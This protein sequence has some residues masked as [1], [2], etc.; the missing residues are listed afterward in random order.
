MRH[1]FFCLAMLLPMQAAFAQDTSQTLSDR[2]QRD[3]QGVGVIAA[4]IENNTPVFTSLGVTQVGGQ[5]PVDA[6]T[7]FEIGSISK[8]FVNLLLAQMVLD[9]TMTLDDPLAQYL[10]EGTKLPAFDGQ[11]ITLRHLAT[12]RSGLPSVPPSLGTIDPLNP[13]E[14]F[15][16]EPFYAFLATFSL[17][18]APGT[19]FQY[20]NMGTTL[21]AEAI[22][23]AAGKPYED[24]V[25]ERI[26]MPLGMGQTALAPVD[27]QRFAS[28]HDTSGQPVPHWTFDVF[29]PAG[30]YVSSAADLAKFATAASGQRETPLDPAFALMLEQLHP[31]DAP[32]MKIGLGWMVLEHPNGTTVWHNGKTGGF[33]SFIGFDSAT[34]KAAIVLAN[35]VTA[36]GIEDIGFHLIDPK[37]PL[38]PQPKPRQQVTIDP[39]ILSN[40]IGTYELGPEFSIAV[41][42]EGGQLFIQASGQERFPAFPESDTKFFLKVVD[43]QISFERGQDGA[44]T[45]LVLHQNGQAIPGAKQ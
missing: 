42:A 20:S 40:Y 7:L 30:A 26:L 9:G 17:V 1:L 39:A 41:T 31:A 37:A 15:G 35:A 2:L 8:L 24:L 28:G 23:H 33:N 22:S 27:P 3:G 21:L 25:R 5:T 44:V 16:T 11:K 36:T 18:E 13:Y 10:P 4:V 34:G 6:T 43:A 19:R 38:A 14:G 45:G 32:N 29:A 12:H